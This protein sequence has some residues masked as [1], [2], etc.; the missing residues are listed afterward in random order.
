M[1]YDSE[2]ERIKAGVRRIANNHARNMSDAQV[3]SWAETLRPYAGPVLMR[4]LDDF[5]IGDEFPNV[6]GI[7]AKYF[8]LTQS[9]K[10]PRPQTEAERKKADHAA[11]VSM[12]W[13]HYEKGWRLE[14]FDGSPMARAF[15]GL[16]FAQRD[17]NDEQRA[18]VMRALRAAKMH[19]DRA[20]IAR[21]F[22]Q[23]EQSA[24]RE[25]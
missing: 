8:G 22:E 25:S 14:D 6:G 5:A 19:Y 10:T 12:L 13:L 24:A 2:T 18:E 17:M 23:L 9:S 3:T 1:S 15:L 20:T 7:R 16:S 11:I 21:L 4:V